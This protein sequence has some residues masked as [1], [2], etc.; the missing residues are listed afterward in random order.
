MA[1]LEKI[2]S[3][4]V[5]LF[6]IIGLALL[7]FIF[8]DAERIVHTLFGPGSTV[9]QVEGHKIDAQEFSRRVEEASQMMQQRG[10]KVD[11]AVL[12]QQV[13]DQM[14][15]EA[16]FKEEC[17]KLGLT[18]TDAELRE[19]MLGS[20]NN[21]V[22][23]TVQ[24]QVGVESAAV[25]YDLA[26]NPAKN[27][28]PAEQAQMLKDYWIN[29][30]NDIEQQLLQAKFQNLI[31]GTLVANKLDTKAMYE[32][33]KATNHI[34]YVRKEY[35][36]LPDKDFE[37]TDAEVKAEWDQHKNR[38]KLQEETRTV[39]YIAVNIVPSDADNAEAARKVADALKGLNEKPETL[40]LEGMNGFIADRQKLTGS[41]IRDPK[42][43]SFADSAAIG[44]A[45]EIS[46]V[47]DTYTLAKLLGK[48]TETDSVLID[49]IAVQGTRAQVD[50]MVKS[51]NGG[52]NFKDV[53]ASDIVAQSQ[54]SMYVSLVDP[55]SAA[56]AEFINNATIGTYF[57]PDTI[58]DAQGGRIFRVRERKNPT[59]VYDLAVVTYTVEPSQATIA[60]LTEDLMAYVEKNQKAADFAANAGKSN[61][62]AVPA[63]VSASTPMLGNLPESR[64]LVAWAMEAKAGEVSQVFDDNTDRVVAVAVNNIYKDYVPASDPQVKEMLTTTV[65]NDKKA[66][67]MIAQ[68]QGKAKDLAGYAQVMGSKVDSTT[69]NFGQPFIP[70]FGMN[71]PMMTAKVATAKAKTLV[72][73]FQ[74]NSGVVVFM[75]DTVDT[76]GRPYNFDEVATQYQQ[77]RGANV[78]LRNLAG[79]LLGNNKIENNILKIYNRQR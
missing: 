15:A 14:I 23:Q 20:Q 56:I 69:V 39:N 16:L 72:G 25:L 63:Q 71:E 19:A 1:T 61:Y 64:D 62:T 2:R 28:V 51:L 35:S 40:G 24:Q 26:F 12:Q 4:S 38:Y 50:S 48:T 65:R 43:K 60:K 34:A 29:L 5:F 77:T 53:V 30:E 46:K 76:A 42:L 59:T 13:L 31:F 67:H 75:I 78:A 68:Y 55:N 3:K 52:A 17:E 57:T 22:N 37:V 44:S 8:T 47:G 27:Q 74:T 58:A 36:S 11:M 33:N 66:Q 32:D 70:G 6:I 7:A 45:K 10:Q 41:S 18:V 54:D 73:P 9:A 21:F 79:I 49:F